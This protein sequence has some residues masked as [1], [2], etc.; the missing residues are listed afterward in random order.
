MVPIHLTGLI[1]HSLPLSNS[2]CSHSLPLQQGISRSFSSTLLLG[3][4]RQST[5]WINLKKKKIIKRCRDAHRII[6]SALQNKAVVIKPRTSSHTTPN[7]LQY[8]HYGPQ[9]QAPYVT[10]FHAKSVAQA[11]HYCCISWCLQK[12]SLFPIHFILLVL[13]SVFYIYV[14][15]AEFMQTWLYLNCKGSWENEYLI[16]LT[17]FHWTLSL[18][19]LIK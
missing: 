16:F 19:K 13:N 15:K 8:R 10:I 17:F 5:T 18:P 6:R 11:T 1:C 9:C 14:P 2:S 4:K 7:S 12:T 3:C